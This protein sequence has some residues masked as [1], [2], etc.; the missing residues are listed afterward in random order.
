MP[1]FF[2]FFV[3]GF[4][5]GGE[6]QGGLAVCGFQGEDIPGVGGDYQGGDEV[7]LVGAVGDVA[8]ADGADVGVLALAQGAFDLDAEEVSGAVPSVAVALSGQAKARS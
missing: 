1:G 6:G 4:F 3:F 8:G 7:Q 2:V 5:Q